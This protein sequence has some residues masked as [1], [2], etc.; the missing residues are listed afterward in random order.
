LGNKSLTGWSGPFA[1]RYCD[2]AAWALIAIA[3]LSDRFKLEGPEPER[4]RTITALGDWWKTD[5]GT[6]DWSALLRELETSKKE[7][8][9]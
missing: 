2:E 9:K 4:D 3:H 6:V 5:G 8:K 7:V 1:I